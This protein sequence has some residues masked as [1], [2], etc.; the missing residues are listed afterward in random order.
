MC[1]GSVSSITRVA[2]GGGGVA[3]WVRTRRRRRSPRPSA[4][5]GAAA[6]ALAR[7]PPAGHFHGHRRLPPG[8]RPGGLGVVPLKGG[9]AFPQVSVAKRGEAADPLLPG[10]R[11]EGA[12]AALRLGTACREGCWPPFWELLC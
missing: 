7:R 9:A 10:E 1:D 3:G 6:A 5:T 8:W 2:V 4:G 12:P 11:E